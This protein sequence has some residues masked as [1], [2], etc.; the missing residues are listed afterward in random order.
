MKLT[1]ESLRGYAMS[2]PDGRSTKKALKFWTDRATENTKIAPRARDGEV[3]N[4]DTG[5]PT[6][7]PRKKG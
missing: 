7:S 4:F 3:R 6:K 5:S 2:G 1:G